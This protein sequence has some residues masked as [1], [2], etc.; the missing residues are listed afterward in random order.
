[1]RPALGGKK[2]PSTVFF[3][4]FAATNELRSHGSVGRVPSPGAA[5][6]AVDELWTAS[7]LLQNILSAEGRFFA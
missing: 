2:P 3:V 6:K 5:L 7:S 4:S 1:M